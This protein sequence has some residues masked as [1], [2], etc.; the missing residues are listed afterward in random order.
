MATNRKTTKKKRE[1]RFTPRSLGDMIDLALATTDPET[2]ARVEAAA[3]LLDDRHSLRNRIAIVVQ[4]PAATEVGGKGYWNRIGY[5]Q[6][7]GQKGLAIFF[8]AGSDKKDRD[9]TPEEDAAGQDTTA[10]DQEN[11]DKPTRRWSGYG[12]NYVWDRTQVVPFACTC[13]TGCTCP[14]PPEGKV[15]PAGPD[16]EGFAAIV[17]EA[18]ANI[19]PDGHENEG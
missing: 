5:R 17:A 12:I 11:T 15:A 16:R 4:N 7:R 14:P 1:P 18:I 19:Q 3:A 9:T 13:A 6:A 10:T 8:K 2:L